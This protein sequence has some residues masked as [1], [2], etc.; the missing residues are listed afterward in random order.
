MRLLFFILT[1]GLAAFAQNR[2]AE[3]D[4][5]ADRLFDE[6]VFRYDPASATQAGFH[7]FDEPAA[8]DVAGGN[9]FGHRRLEEI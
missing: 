3:F 6:V 1:S 7:R 9:R 4:Q 8:V 2:D 5:L